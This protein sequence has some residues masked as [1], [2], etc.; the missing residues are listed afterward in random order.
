MVEYAKQYIAFLSSVPGLLLGGPDALERVQGQLDNGM[1]VD[2]TQGSTQG[3]N[4]NDDSDSN[5]I[6]S[7]P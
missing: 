3:D 5:D 4:L 1:E 7:M 2:R 6:Y